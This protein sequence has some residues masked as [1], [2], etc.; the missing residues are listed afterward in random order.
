MSVWKSILEGIVFRLA[1]GFQNILEVFFRYA[2]CPLRFCLTG[3]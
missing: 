3:Q 1:L 2:P